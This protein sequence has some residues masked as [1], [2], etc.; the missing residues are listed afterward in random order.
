MS[1]EFEQYERS[2]EEIRVENAALLIEFIGWMRQ[3]GIS[4]RTVGMYFS[5]AAFYVQEFLLNEQPLR[6]QEGA[7]SIG[8][9][10]GY[11]FIRNGPSATP[12]TV[13]SNAASLV[14]F[15]S[16]LAE[17]GLV[18][19]EQLGRM[20]KT[21]KIELAHWQERA[22]RYNDPAITDPSKIWI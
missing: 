11:W 12:G 2:C 7:A 17:K 21:I 1:E 22:R 13:K 6:P 15:Y 19:A 3:Q 4:I 5:N 9:Y 16:F 18:T 8:M 14:K 10:L 20:R